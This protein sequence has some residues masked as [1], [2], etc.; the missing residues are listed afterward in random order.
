MLENAH[1]GAHVAFACLSDTGR[2]ARSGTGMES[3]HC[4]PREVT[5]RV[6]EPHPRATS[7][8]FGQGETPAK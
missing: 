7:K 1:T 8:A 6:W 5:Q 4:H 3:F 2:I